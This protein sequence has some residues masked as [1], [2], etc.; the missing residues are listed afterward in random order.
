MFNEITYN[1]LTD[2]EP[3][4][5]DDDQSLIGNG[6][7]FRHHRACAVDEPCDQ[8]FAVYRDN[9]LHDRTISFNETLGDF[10]LSACENKEGLSDYLD[11]V[12]EVGKATLDEGYATRE[13]ANHF[14]CILDIDRRKQELLLMKAS[15]IDF[16]LDLL[17]NTLGMK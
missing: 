3:G 16:S 13:H 8:V 10:L 12:A 17:K 9:C 4:F 2:T 14:S 6:P 15:I 7:S 1:P 11:P 5:L